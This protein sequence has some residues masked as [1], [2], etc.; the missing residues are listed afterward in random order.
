MSNNFQNKFSN[1]E[2]CKEDIVTNLHLETAKIPWLELQRFFASGKL[3]LLKSSEDMLD[4]A[5]SLV[6]N[7]VERL[8]QL[9]DHEIIIH[10]SDQQ[11]K[12]WLKDDAILWAV[13]LNPW[14]LVQEST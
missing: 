7:D 5:T 11:A 9:I 12:R 2:I 8:K 10:P 1:E 4:V 3:L 13:V 6:V 14:V